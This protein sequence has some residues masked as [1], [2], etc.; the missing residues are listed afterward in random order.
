RSSVPASRRLHSSTRTAFD[1][2]ASDTCDGLNKNGRAL[3]PAAKSRGSNRRQNTAAPGLRRQ[4]L[5][6]AIEHFLGIAEQ[7]ACVLLVEK[8]IV[9][10]GIARRHAAFEHHHRFCLPYL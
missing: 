3:G 9:H 2:W 6:N 8:R 10:A 4:V 5:Q 1:A 7:H